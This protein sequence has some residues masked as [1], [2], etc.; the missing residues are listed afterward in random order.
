[1]L[2]PAIL[3]AI[4]N[5]K[6]MRSKSPVKGNGGRSKKQTNNTMNNNRKHG[7]KNRSQSKTQGKSNSP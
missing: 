5:L 3:S 4:K 7:S 6:P 2:N 1:V